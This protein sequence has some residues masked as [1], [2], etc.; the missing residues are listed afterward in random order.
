M[1]CPFCLADVQFI[2]EKGY[3]CPECSEQVPPMYVRGYKDYPPLVVSAVGLRGHGKTVYFASLFYLLK[4]SPL[5]AFWQPDFFA[6]SLSDRDLETVHSNAQ[7]LKDGKLPGSTPMNFPRPTMLR[8]AGIPMWPKQRNCTLVFYDTSGESFE[9]ASELVK[10][11][12][13]AQQAEMVML[14]N[15]YLIGIEDLGGSTRHQDLMVVYTKA[16]EMDECLAPS[17]WN[18]VRT[19]LDDGSVNSLAQVK[20][21]QRQMYETSNYLYDFT[22]VALKAD[23]FMNLAQTNFRGVGFSIVSALGSAPEDGHMATQVNPLRVLDP[24]IWMI[25]RSPSLSEKRSGCVEQLNWMTFAF[26]GGVVYGAVG[27]VLGGLMGGSRNAATWALVLGA[28]LGLV[29]GLMG[30]QI[31]KNWKVLLDPKQWASASLG[32]LLGSG[33][34]GGAVGAVV[35]FLEVLLTRG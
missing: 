27:G 25:G 23:E 21:Y 3:F 30:G 16:D 2:L 7:M 32:V 24:V 20:T 31:A 35:G 33:G 11:A 34:V 13:F 15:T 12:R 6:L 14:L 26:L 18:A 10:Y 1:L 29:G 8:V 28:F 19:Y 22:R 17:P 5:S 9:R 4:E